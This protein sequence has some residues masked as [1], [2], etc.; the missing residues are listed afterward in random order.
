[1]TR[2]EAL[3]RAA[4]GATG[5][6]A[7]PWGAD[8]RIAFGESGGRHYLSVRFAD[9]QELTCRWNRAQGSI[10]YGDCALDPLDAPSW[11]HRL[12]NPPPPPDAHPRRGRGPRED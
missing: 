2:K 9:G 3:D 12:G 6:W 11:T 10:D 5:A 8:A 4:T 1:M 7:E